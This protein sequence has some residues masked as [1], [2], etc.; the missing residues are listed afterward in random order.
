[1]FRAV[2]L[3]DQYP[4]ALFQ[5]WLEEQGFKV[6]RFWNTDVYDDLEVVLEAIWRECEARKK[7]PSPP[8]PLP[9]V[10]GRGEEDGPL[11]RFGGEGLG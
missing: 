6:L 11:P 8:A 4:L 5:L 3:P 9:G 1:M 10:P 2:D 7:N